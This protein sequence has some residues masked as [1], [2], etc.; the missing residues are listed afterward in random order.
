MGGFFIYMA[1]LVHQS[2]KALLDVLP[3]KKRP[4]FGLPFEMGLK[5]LYRRFHIYT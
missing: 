5:R 4:T 3:A 1:T 2:R